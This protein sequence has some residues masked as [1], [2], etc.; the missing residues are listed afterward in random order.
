MVGEPKRFEQRDKQWGKRVAV[1]M[2]VGERLINKSVFFSDTS[3]KGT[4]VG[5]FQIGLKIGQIKCNVG[6]INNTQQPHT[7]SLIS[8]HG[9]YIGFHV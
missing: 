8:H 2:G 4:P 3:P 6:S 5:Q 9:G 7:K 1:S